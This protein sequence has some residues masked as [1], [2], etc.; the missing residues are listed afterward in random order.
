MKHRFIEV[1][2]HS[3][4]VRR[5][6]KKL[7][8]IR[9]QNFKIGGEMDGCSEL[10]SHSVSQCAKQLGGVLAKISTQAEYDEAAGFIATS[11]AGSKQAWIG[12][13]DIGSEGTFHFVE[14]NSVLGAFQVNHKL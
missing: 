1:F 11:A 10:V 14:D 5:A 4:T 12:L 9:F 2:A 13:N 8:S 6:I 7:V 3:K